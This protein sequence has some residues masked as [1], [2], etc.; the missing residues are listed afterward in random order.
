MSRA[1]L[2]SGGKVAS[3]AKKLR[4]LYG[5]HKPQFN[6]ETDPDVHLLENDASIKIE[7]VRE[8]E[9]LLSLKP[10]GTSPK[11]VVISQAEKLTLEAQGALLKI[12][13]EPPGET[14]FLLTAGEETVLLP[15]IVSRCQQVFLSQEAEIELEK[16][17]IARIE[18]LISKIQKAGAGERLKIAENF[19]TREETIAFCQKQLVFWREKLLADPSPQTLKILREIQKTLKYLSANV[20]PRLAIENLLLSYKIL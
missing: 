16:E 3:R 2:I 15:T 4:E 10:R 12:L 19:S 17:E 13:E 1:Y 8:L 9:R 14:I 5:Q 20:N 18:E 6:F 11:I 7:D